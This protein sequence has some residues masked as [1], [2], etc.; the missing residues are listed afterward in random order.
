M[1][2]GDSGLWILDVKRRDA[3]LVLASPAQRGVWS[4]DKSWMSILVAQP[5]GDE[6]WLA[7][8]DPNLPTYESLA[9]ASTWGDYVRSRC[10]RCRNLVT[11]TPTQ[12]E[13]HLRKLSVFGT[14]QYRRGQYEDSILA[15]STADQLRRE[16][17]GEDS[18]LSEV[19]LE[20]GPVSFGSLR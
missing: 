5:Y 15:L 6:I 12:A 19:A 13:E 17:L 8:L 11:R 1:A 20:P 3:R 2:A 9:P 10:E 18:P 16:V 7:R 14:D 4:P